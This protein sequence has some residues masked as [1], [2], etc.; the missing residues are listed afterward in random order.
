M[1]KLEKLS[2]WRQKKLL[3]G[4]QFGVYNLIKQP[5]SC[6]VYKI[7]LREICLKNLKNSI[8]FSS[9]HQLKINMIFSFNK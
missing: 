3:M 8:M 9:I 4:S 7:K 5:V 2:M 1:K 6:I